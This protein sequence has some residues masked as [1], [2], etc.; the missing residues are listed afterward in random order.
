MRWALNRQASELIEFIIRW[1]QPPRQ[2]VDVALVVQRNH[3]ALPA[4]RYRSSASRWS[5]I[6][7]ETWLVP[8]PMAKPFVPS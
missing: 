3:F 8:L 4:R 1:I 5:L 6:W 7:S 2:T